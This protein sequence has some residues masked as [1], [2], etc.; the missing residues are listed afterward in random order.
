MGLVFAFLSIPL[1]LIGSMV[2]KANLVDYAALDNLSSYMGCYPNWGYNE[3]REDFKTQYKG[4]LSKLESA[5]G[6]I[7]KLILSQDKPIPTDKPKS[8][9]NI[10]AAKD[11]IDC[12]GPDYKTFKTTAQKCKEYQEAWH[13]TPKTFPTIS[14]KTVNSGLISYSCVIKG[15]TY[16]LKV[17]SENDGLFYCNDNKRLI[18]ELEAQNAQ[19]AAEDAALQK[20]ISDDL[21]KITS[22]TYTPG[23]TIA[24]VT[25]E[26]LPTLPPVTTSCYMRTQSDPN[27]RCLNGV[28]LSGEQCYQVCN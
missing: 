25:Y 27:D 20:K 7:G 12:T 21:N 24:P 6:C 5:K 11:Q 3:A 9:V 19:W 1:L 2:F 4:N 18:A 26:P 23:P 14:Q 15:K 16:I 8:E 22:T 28:S 10:G 13:F 17:K